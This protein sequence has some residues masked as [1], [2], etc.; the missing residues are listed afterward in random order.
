MPRYTTQKQLT[1]QNSYDTN[2]CWRILDI[3]NKSQLA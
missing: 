2:D 3:M 1:I